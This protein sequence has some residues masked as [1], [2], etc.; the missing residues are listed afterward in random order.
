MLEICWRWTGEINSQQPA[1][2]FPP[3]CVAA[4][5]VP[6]SLYAPAHFI[7]FFFSNKANFSLRLFVGQE[8]ISGKIKF[9][10]SGFELCELVPSH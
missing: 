8:L 4:V 10:L 3:P 7:F 6:H 2:P 5:T 1:R 9:A